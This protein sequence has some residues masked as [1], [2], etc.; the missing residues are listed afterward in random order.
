MTKGQR[1]MLSWS[2]V[3]MTAP[4]VVQHNTL[5][6]DVS[7]FRPSTRQHDDPVNNSSSAT[8]RGPSMAGAGSPTLYITQDMGGTVY[9]L[10]AIDSDHEDPQ[11]ELVQQL[12]LSSANQVLM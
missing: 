11:Q 8:G 9:F 7:E 5:N 1:Y 3:R 4:A 2:F 6:L 10:R 12:F